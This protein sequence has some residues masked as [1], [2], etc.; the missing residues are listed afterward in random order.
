MP[1]YKGE[2]CLKLGLQWHS[3]IKTL[4]YLFLSFYRLETY[5][6]S[7]QGFEL[8]QSEEI[9][10]FQKKNIYQSMIKYVLSVFFYLMV[11]LTCKLVLFFA[12]SLTKHLKEFILERQKT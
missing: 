4:I 12:K 1:S 10:K 6:K 8:L 11:S 5:D 2:I 3:P 7:A 9:G